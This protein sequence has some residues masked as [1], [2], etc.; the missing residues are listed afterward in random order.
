MFADG[1]RLRTLVTLVATRWLAAASAA[2]AQSRRRV[3]PYDGSIPFNCELQDVGT[4][5]DF[6]DPGR[7]PVLRRVRQDEPERHRL[8]ARRLRRPGAGAGRGRGD[9]VL[10]L[11]ARPLDRLGRP[12]PGARALALGR[13]LLLRPRPR[14]SAGS[15]CATSAL[16]GSRRT[17]PR[18]CPPAYRPTSTRTAAAASRC[19]SRR[20]RTRPAPRRSTPRR[21]AT[22][23]RR[24]R[25]VRRLHRARRRAPG[26]ARRPGAARDDAAS[27]VR[28]RLGPPSDARRRIDRWCLVGKGELRVAYGRE[29]RAALI[30]TSG[31][32][33]SIHGV[34]RGDRPA[35][36]AAAPRD[37]RAAAPARRRDE[38]LVVRRTG[39]RRRLDRRSAGTACAG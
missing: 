11:P 25:R 26:Q 9:Q 10:L 6:P 2:G 18:T 30:L 14:A 31:R 20:T 35:A 22:R 21:S 29:A 34:A 17:R 39:D 3:A 23:L 28:A 27:G 5:T 32:G 16:G 15:A 37:R 24:P 1:G 4:G 33:H 8:R 12:G 13:R 19:C 36:R 38:V 7:R